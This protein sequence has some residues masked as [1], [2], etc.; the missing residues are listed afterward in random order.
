MWLVTLV[1]AFAA[2]VALS[3]FR[4]IRQFRHYES[5]D[6]DLR[7]NGAGPLPTIAIIVPARNEAANIE[8]CLTSLLG[9][10]YPAGRLQVTVVDDNSDDDTGDI[11]QRVSDGDGRVRL[12]K[13]ADLPAGWV[14]KT[15]A[16]WHGAT[17]ADAE[18][19]CFIDADTRAAPAL[20]QSAIRFACMRKLDMLSLEPFQELSG[21]LDRLVFPLGF[22]AI[23]ATQDLA[24]VNG[25]D[26][27]AATANGQF[28]LIRAA[29]YF[30][31]GGHSAV[32][33]AICEDSA[34]A[35]RIKDAGMSLA[36]VGAERL[37]RTRMYANMTELWEGLSKNATQ[38][39]GGPGRTLAIAAVGLAIGWASLALPGFAAF[40][41][42]TEPNPVWIAVFILAALAS[43][44]VYATQFAL[45]RRFRIPAW[46][47]LLFPL[48]CSVGAI[49]AANAVLIR[50]RGRI[51]WKGRVYVHRQERG[52]VLGIIGDGR[53]PD[54]GS[55][56]IE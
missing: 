24:R 22:L 16:C 42:A 20:M 4:A 49:I 7:V 1:S 2:I 17:A 52:T 6:P 18:W 12:I 39:Y 48:S 23:A 53:A 56:R 45:A 40:A 14:G 38:T 11:V 55:S 54:I 35:R 50:G 34:L 51:A 13:A 5:I 33:K 15:H 19:L 26:A 31:V 32:R 28:I 47:G 27:A 36:V 10:Q 21:F 30:A 8:E 3:L 44:A 9:Q 46:Y 37:I 41:A 25:R 29:S 43:I